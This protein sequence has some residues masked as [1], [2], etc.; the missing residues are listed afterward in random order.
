MLAPPRGLQGFFCVCARRCSPHRITCIRFS[1]SL[2]VVLAHARAAALL[3]PAFSAVV[4]AD[5]R[6]A[7]FLALD[8]SAVVLA[9]ARPAELLALASYA[10]VLADARPAALLALASCAVVLADARPAALLALASLAVVL[11]CHVQ[12]KI[13]SHRHLMLRLYLPRAR[14]YN[15]VGHQ[16]RRATHSPHREIQR[17]S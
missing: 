6:A 12:R 16:T 10:A 5:A 3:A 11:I 4:L 14:S 9:D 1:E 15:I 7:A 8:S 13:H 2:A 17:P